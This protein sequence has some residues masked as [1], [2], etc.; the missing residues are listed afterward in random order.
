MLEKCQTWVET[1]ASVE[2]SLQNL[3]FEKS[4]Q[5]TRKIRYQIFLYQIFYI[6]FFKNF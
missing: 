4:S 6:K 1:Q 3:N 5:K 2:S